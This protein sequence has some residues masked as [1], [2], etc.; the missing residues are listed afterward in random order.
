MIDKQTLYKCRKGNQAAF[1]SLYNNSVPYV[2]SIVKRYIYDQSM[3]K[4]LVQEAYAQIF[5]SLNKYDESKG[6]L[7]PYL[8]RITVNVCLL[9]LRKLKSLPILNSVEAIYE[10]PYNDP[11]QENI[12]NLNRQD[13]EAI[14]KD[15]PIGYRTVFLLHIIDEFDYDEISKMLDI[16]KE[17][18][19]SQYFRAKKWIANKSIIDLKSS[20]YGLF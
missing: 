12:Q 20:T 9:H 19:R 15:M 18:V 4:D 5:Q 14:L 16:S 13:I 2:Y 8:R 1:R 17:T 3:V 6:E 11:A 10:E 7:K